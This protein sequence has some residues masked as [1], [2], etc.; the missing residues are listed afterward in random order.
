[1]KKS[2]PNIKGK[3]QGAATL[4][5][6]KLGALTDDPIV[7]ED[8][9]H[10]AAAIVKSLKEQGINSKASKQPIVSNKTKIGDS[11]RLTCGY[12][13]CPKVCMVKDYAGTAPKNE[14]DSESNSDSD[15][16]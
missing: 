15:R 4:K 7:D 2:N 12:Q 9:R 3:P 6:Y 11:Y 1:M 8:I 13:V 16:D 14:T 10:D 5:Y